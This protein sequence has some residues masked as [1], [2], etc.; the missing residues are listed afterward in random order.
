MPRLSLSLNIR[1]KVLVALL[2]CLAAVGFLAALSLSRLSEIE[3]KLT[4]VE[5][6]SD[7]SDTF[8]EARRYE[9]NYLLYA[10]AP[11]LDAAVSFAE[12]AMGVCEAI[13]TKSKS[14]YAVAVVRELREANMAYLDSLSDMRGHM[15][16]KILDQESQERM[17]GQGKDLVERA[18]GLVQ[19][20]RTRVSGITAS[21]RAQLLFAV[22][23][24]V[25]MAVALM[26]LV[27]DKIIRPL[28]AIEEATRRI[29]RGEFSTLDAPRGRD[30]T[31]RVL[32][33][34]DTM[35]RELEMR[36][37][38]LVQAK[39][40]SSIGTLAAGIAHQLNNPLNNI[41]TSCQIAM[42][43][44]DSGDREFLL[45]MLGNVDRETLRARDIVRGLLEFSRDKEFSLVPTPVAEVVHAAVRLASGQ[46]PPGVEL[47][48]DVPGE[49]TAL[50]DKQK[51]QEVFINLIINAVQAIKDKQGFIRL[52]AK[53]VDDEAPNTPPGIEIKIA[54]SG[55]GIPEPIQ[56]Q[57]FDP[58]FTT[59]DV[60]AGTGLGLSI[61]YGIVKK[62]GGTITV[63][64]APGQGAQFI[65]RLSAGDRP[66]S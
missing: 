46:V 47:A 28:A 34:F 60:G 62:H 16:G 58:F 51:M 1:H 37:D 17:R 10:L 48:V 36:Q 2:A 35:V 25:V 12:K 23:A 19:F 49:L 52:S 33:A 7:L 41:S 6:A 4:V 15:G 29:A 39:K 42:E 22:S 11:D 50:M 9:K 21:L 65:I 54:D 57:I 64:S 44:F 5:L 32:I 14:A 27:R 66:Q 59:K 45:K 30:E 18:L 38:Q 55:A 53:A 56:Q 8:L 24:F 63:R 20:E 31:G 40:L 13:E 26:F 3:D 61:V 43:E